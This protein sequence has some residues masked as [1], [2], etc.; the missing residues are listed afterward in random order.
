MLLLATVAAV[1]LSLDPVNTLTPAFATHVFG[2]ADTFAGVLIGAFGVG[3]VVASVLPAGATSRD[4]SRPPSRVIPGAL[5]LFGGGIVA[6]AFA[7][8]LGV[9]YAALPV[10][11]FGYLLA[12]TRATTELQLGVS[13]EERGR[14]MALW[15]VA[16][17]GTRPVASSADG[18]LADLLG[19]RLT[20]GLFAGPALVAAVVM[21]R[22]Q[23]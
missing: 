15:S 14:V 4:G 18:G 20:A 16:F 9:A 6:F 21:A 8:G 23:R 1:S 10:A 13:D 5:L 2:R 7:P 17:L 19:P 3:A 22:R 12:Q 11:G